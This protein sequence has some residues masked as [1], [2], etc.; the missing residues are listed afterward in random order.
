MM[1]VTLAFVLMNSTSLAQESP[2]HNIQFSNIGKEQGLS[3]PKV[4]CLLQDSKGFLWLGT[5]DGLN[6]Y[7]GASIK[8]YKVTSSTQADKKQGLVSNHIQTLFEDRE[9]FLWVGTY[10][11]G[12]CRFDRKTGIFL[13]FRHDP[14][15]PKSLPSN[16]I[17]S[18]FQDHKGR[19]WVGTLGGGV[20][21]FIPEKQEFKTF[22]SRHNPGSALPNDSVSSIYEDRSGVLWLGTFGGGLAAF[23][24]TDERFT[25]YTHRSDDSLSLPTNCVRV[26]Y[27]DRTGNLW[28]GTGGKGLARLDRKTRRFTTFQHEEDNPRSLNNNYVMD[29]Q[30]DSLGVLWIATKGGGLN[31]FDHRKG[32]FSAYMRNLSVP[33]SLSHNDINDL[34]LDKVGSLWIAT[35]GG[36][37][38]RF[39]TQERQVFTAF[40]SDTNS[41]FAARSITSLFEDHEKRLWLGTSDKGIYIFDWDKKQ[42]IAFKNYPSHP[43]ALSNDGI[44]AICEDRY[45]EIWMGTGNSG[46][47]KYNPTEQTFKVYTAN[48]DNVNSL[49]S[50]AI[51][52]LFKDSKG[53]LWVGTNGG[54]LCM[55]DADSDSFI[56]FQHNPADPRS[57]GG[58]H[59]TAICED[60]TGKLW[61][62][63]Q[64]SGLSVFNPKDQQFINYRSRPNQ[65]DGLSSD[66]IRAIEE[67][68]NGILWIG[69]AG[70]GISKFNPSKGKF[71]SLTDRVSLLDN[72]ICGIVKDKM[73][74]M[75]ISTTKGLF[76]YDWASL[77]FKHFTVEDGLPSNEFV[78]GAFEVSTSGELF[79]G[80][81]GSFIAFRPQ[82]VRDNA[83]VA[84]VHLTAFRLFDKIMQFE[85]DFMHLKEINLE[86]DDNFISFEFVLLDFLAPEKNLYAYTLEGFDRGWNY[87]G[88]RHFASY[89]NLDAG[90]YTFRVKAMGK[91]GIWN[92][93]GTSIRLVI[94]PVWYKT[95]WF[96][97]LATLSTLGIAFSFYRQRIH[98]IERQKAVLEAQVKERTADLQEEKSKV[99]KA[100]AEINFQKEQLQS[101]DFHLTSSINYAKRIQH[102][103]L[104]EPQDIQ[105]SL[106]DS[107]IL[108]KPRDTVSGDFYWFARKGDLLLIAAIDCT[109][110]GI[111]G[112]LMSMVGNS[113]LNQIVNE[114]NII[115]PAEILRRLHQGI[116]FAFKQDSAE[117]GALD[118]MDIALCVVH[119]N[120]NLIEFAGANRPLW[121]IHDGQLTELKP[122]GTTAGGPMHDTEGRYSYSSLQIDQPTNIYLFTDGF[123][124]QFGGEH[125]RKFMLKNFKQLLLDVQ[126][127]DFP[128]QKEILNNT[129]ETWKGQNFQT[130]DMLVIGFRVG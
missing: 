54:G 65:P 107:F 49:T 121:H 52:T 71:T 125:H 75:W 98:I 27:E 29:I 120:D 44:T 12:L 56:P 82:S 6:L 50:N 94:H 90:A 129:I 72:T 115:R 78:P 16:R 127:L 25:T 24:N 21:R 80:S 35:D 10:D 122:T 37:V 40:V 101:K 109:G 95:W 76:R 84:P 87:V 64:A 62:G 105:Q 23:H 110:H 68:D 31:R 111:P 73:N 69:T 99:E 42:F 116:R 34:Y 79:F 81:Q 83:Y 102:S 126:S 66:S 45:G 1:A 17:S 39:E 130:D 2:A 11:A 20:S 119:L 48:A 77:Q 28:V 100:Y 13:Q 38:C 7:D 60:R 58:N 106:P 123:A 59:I 19:L 15:N 97:I 117:E 57:I 74:N 118:G 114:L 53:S 89:T 8:V 112:A 9:G 70:A 91:N 108:L 22:S 113:L 104:P 26:V 61:I 32:I 30:E 96:R 4:S 85:E 3:Y 86:H 33:Q 55:F 128:A 124:D 92:E 51:G 103:L 67:A 47:Y 18:I 36:G 41:S 43:A 14:A 5:N 63:H 46:L 88:N 93:T